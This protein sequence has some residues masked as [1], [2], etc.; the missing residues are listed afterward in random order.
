MIIILSLHDGEMG[1]LSMTQFC[2]T[3]KEEKPRQVS[4]R[5]LSEGYT[6]PLFQRSKNTEQWKLRATLS[7]EDFQFQSSK[8]A[9]AF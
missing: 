4:T 8:P 9:V 1:E 6:F 7:K 3:K 2:K 5:K